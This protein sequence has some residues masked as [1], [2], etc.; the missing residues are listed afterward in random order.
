MKSGRRGRPL[1][2]GT[3]KWVAH[4]VGIEDAVL[5]PRPRATVP[6]SS[7]ERPDQDHER[8]D[9]HGTEAGERERRRQA[10]PDLRPVPTGSLGRHRGKFEKRIALESVVHC[11]RFTVPSHGGCS[12][13]PARESL[14]RAV[15]SFRSPAVRVQA[16]MSP[17]APNEHSDVGRSETADGSNYQVK[18]ESG[19]EVADGSNYRDQDADDTEVADG[20]NYQVQDEPGPTVADGSNYRDEP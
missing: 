20:S 10:E 2:G 3:R 4:V 7:G 1:I 9:A 13:W 15:A 8:P 18:D 5:V 17:D 16:I 6:V 11:V 19:S 12:N 14:V